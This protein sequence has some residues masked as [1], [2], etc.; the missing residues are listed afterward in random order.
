MIENEI[1]GFDPSQLTVFNKT[2]QETKSF[3]SNVYRPRPAESQSEDGHYYAT[4]KIIYNPFDLKHSILEQQSYA[5][6]DSEGWFTVVSSLT[7]N[8]RNC[9]IFKAWKKCHFAEKGSNLWKQAAS[10]DEGGNALFDKRFSRYVTIQVI[11]DKN[12]PELEGKYMFWKMPKSILDII[13]AKMN[14]SKESGKAA[15]PVMDFLFG[16]AID[17]EVIPGPGNPGD[18]RY[19]RETKYLAELSEEI[20]SCTNPD[21]SPLLNT[22]E[23]NILDTYINGMLK[24]WRTKDPSERAENLNL[25]NND[26]NTKELRQVYAKVLENIKQFCP[27][28][29]E[30]L[31]YKEWTDD[32]KNRVQNWIN[33]VL[34]ENIPAQSENVPTVINETETTLEPSQMTS[35]EST[36]NDETDDLP[37]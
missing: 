3:N 36:N 29:I 7:N 8:D 5:M 10:K 18:E 21:G 9:P 24:V 19:S 13:N 1:L 12:K 37:F 28:L 30:E 25:V 4:I 2:E 6:Q 26:P 14:P 16:R 11:K 20:V 23:Q 27:N 22:E 32:V 31:G 35:F 33:I 17:L 15:I 34:S